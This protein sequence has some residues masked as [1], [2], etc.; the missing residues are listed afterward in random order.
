MAADE[1]RIATAALGAG[2]WEDHDQIVIAV[3]DRLGL[4]AQHVEAVL[5]RLRIRMVLVCV[6]AAR[7]GSESTASVRYERGMDWTDE[8]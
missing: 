3:A 4:A 7:A 8:Q 1:H 5:Q 6:T 2:S